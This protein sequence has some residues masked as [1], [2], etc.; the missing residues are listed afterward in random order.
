MTI[1][2]LFFMQTV[3]ALMTIGC[4]GHETRTVKIANEVNKEVS[5]PYFSE[6]KAEFVHGKLAKEDFSETWLY[7]YRLSTVN[8]LYGVAQGLSFYFPENPQYIDWHQNTFNEK[9]RRNDYTDHNITRIYWSYINA[10]MFDKA[11]E[12]RKRFPSTAYAAIPDT[13]SISTEAAGAR[14]P[15]YDVFD[16]GKNSE[17]KGLHL[18]EGPKIVVSVSP[19]CPVADRAITEILANPEWAGTFRKYGI[20]LTTRFDV[21]GLLKWREK[22]MFPNMYI[23]YKQSRLPEFNFTVS[24]YF[25][26]M[27]DGK[28]VSSFRSWGKKYPAKFLSGMET[29]GVSPDPAKPAEK[30]I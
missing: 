17:L 6:K 29:I 25:Y 13:M 16:K 10:R 2:L 5:Q 9:V 14:W 4:A 21:E 11:A 1:K 12:I 8:L 27:K 24:P 19:G 22:F 18:E 30:K 20:L 26:F 3:C 28:V 15:V 7:K 23:I